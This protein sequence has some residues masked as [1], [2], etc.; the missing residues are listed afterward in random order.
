MTA[1]RT[2]VLEVEGMTC[3]SCVRHVGA[4]LRQSAGVQSVDV[5]LRER[6]VL[7]RHDADAAKVSDLIESLR[8]AGYPALDASRQ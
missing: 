1:L 7:V 5:D 3:G 8:V 6:T 2:T 4:A